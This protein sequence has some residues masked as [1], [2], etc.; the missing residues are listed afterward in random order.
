MDDVS[1]EH[2]VN[3]ENYSELVDS[4]GDAMDRSYTE[5]DEKF[6]RI[7]ILKVEGNVAWERNVDNGLEQ[8]WKREQTVEDQR[9]N[10][11]KSAWEQVG[12]KVQE[13]CCK[14]ELN[15]CKVGHQNVCDLSDEKVREGLQDRLVERQSL[16]PVV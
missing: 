13:K 7:R 10:L 4:K 14:V 5:Q 2:L 15:G 3:L 12:G 16:K 9:F 1:I 11:E 8:S 6:F